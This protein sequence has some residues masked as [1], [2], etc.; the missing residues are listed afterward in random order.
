MT[1]Y[2]VPKLCIAMVRGSVERGNQNSAKARAA[3]SVE[4]DECGW[5]V[6]HTES[7]TGLGVCSVQQSWDVQRESALQSGL[8]CWI[9]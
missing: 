3:G 9:A 1:Q 7:R 2:A 5:N 6:G 8:R 4:C